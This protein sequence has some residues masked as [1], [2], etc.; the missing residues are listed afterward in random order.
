M[1]GPTREFS[2]E[3]WLG[4]DNNPSPTLFAFGTGH[5]RC[6]ARPFAEQLLTQFLVSMTLHNLHIVLNGRPIYTTRNGNL[7][8]DYQ[9]QQ[10][11]TAEVKP[12]TAPVHSKVAARL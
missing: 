9:P 6:P 11:V 10:P 7:A 8:P 5:R 3:K 2:A 12:V 1:Q 4:G